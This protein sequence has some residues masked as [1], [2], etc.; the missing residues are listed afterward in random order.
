[1]HMILADYPRDDFDIF[2]I[3]SLANQRPHS[4]PDI[5]GQ[6]LIAVFRD[7]YQMNLQIVDRMGCVLLRSHRQENTKALGLKSIVF[8]SDQQ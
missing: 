6:Y 8:T 1:M 2:R 7:P 5:L 3:T 4:L